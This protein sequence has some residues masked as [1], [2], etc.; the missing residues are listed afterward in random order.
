[1]RT[2]AEVFDEWEA[3]E[4]GHWEDVYTQRGFSDWKSW[5]MTYLNGLNIKETQ[6][7]DIVVENPQDYAKQLYVGG[8]NGWKQNRPDESPTTFAQLVQPASDDTRTDV[9]TNT[10]VTNLIG[11]IHDTAI[12]VLKAGD[13]QVVLEGTHRVAA[14]AIE[15]T[16]ETQRSQ[17][18]IT[19]RTADMGANNQHLLKEFASSI[20]TITKPS[21]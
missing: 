15:A 14:L 21:Y 3:S 2:W 1:M 19:F 17:G 11:T 8:W 18:I 10:K 9:R 5:R 20:E 6:W 12:L 7:E 13:L 4:K 16:D